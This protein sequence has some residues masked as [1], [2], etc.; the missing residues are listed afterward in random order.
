VD[1]SFVQITEEMAEDIVES[2]ALDIEW[3][4]DSLMPDGRKFGQP[5]LTNAELLQEYMD[6]GMHD[7]PEACKNWIRTKVQELSFQLLQFGVPIE[8]INSVHPYDIIERA[9]IIYSAKMEKL[10]ERRVKNLTD[11]ITQASQPPMIDEG[12]IDGGSSITT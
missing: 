1:K 10:L 7:N 12:D 6:S 5:K 2:V 9:A 3:I 4:I 11:K 8:A